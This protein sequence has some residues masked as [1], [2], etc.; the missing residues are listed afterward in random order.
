MP[1]NSNTFPILQ[2]ASLLLYEEEFSL[3]CVGLPHRMV[4][5]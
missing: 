5:V 4:V 1:D 2:A 3:C